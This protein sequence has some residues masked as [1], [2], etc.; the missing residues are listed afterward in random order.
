[1]N[2]LLNVRTFCKLALAM[3]NGEFDHINAEGALAN[4]CQ[5]PLLVVNNDQFGLF[6]KHFAQS[7]LNGNGIRVMLAQERWQVTLCCAR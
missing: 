6:G 2:L 5:G 1:M 3:V 4:G 7:P